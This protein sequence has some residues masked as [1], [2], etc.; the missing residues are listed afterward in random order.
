MPALHSPLVGRAS[1]ASHRPCALQI[2]AWTYR[3]LSMRIRRQSPWTVLTIWTCTFIICPYNYDLQKPVHV[4]T[5]IRVVTAIDSVCSTMK[6]KTKILVFSQKIKKNSQIFWKQI[7]NAIFFLLKCYWGIS[8]VVY[9]SFLSNTLR[10]PDWY[11]LTSSN[12]CLI[13]VTH[14][15]IFML[16]LGGYTV[17]GY[18]SE[19]VTDH[20]RWSDF[21]YDHEL[22][23]I[24]SRYFFNLLSLFGNCIF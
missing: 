2:E 3:Q 9:N 13:S 14:G 10:S 12:V 6:L 22:A 1:H 21:L 20:S 5:I 15:R 7:I 16:R 17:C 4:A 19:D 8:V 24:L 18:I 23:F 11:E